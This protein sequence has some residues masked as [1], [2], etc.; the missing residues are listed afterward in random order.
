[1]STEKTTPAEITSLSYENARDELLRVVSALEQ[2]GLTLEES[3]SLWER[4]EHLIAH[5][6]SKLMAASEKIDAVLQSSQSSEEN[7]ETTH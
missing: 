6:R 4:G 7:S 1:M 2:G 3:I 5:C